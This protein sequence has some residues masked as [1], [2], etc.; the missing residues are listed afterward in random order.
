MLALV[1]HILLRRFA[2][3][4]PDLHRPTVSALPL[5][6]L[7]P[8]SP[9]IDILMTEHD[10]S[11]DTKGVPRFEYLSSLP[12]NDP[13]CWEEWKGTKKVWANALSTK[14]NLLD[15]VISF[16]AKTGQGFWT[17]NS[18]VILDEHYGIG[19]VSDLPR[20][21][22]PD[23]LVVRLRATNIIQAHLPPDRL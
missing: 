21:E 6:L 3:A 1:L 11:S 23:R 12:L 5:T 18:K 14:G 19:K 13:M 7:L 2:T 9:H 10:Y 22:A 20:G 17:D 15:W 16:G 4:V 8:L